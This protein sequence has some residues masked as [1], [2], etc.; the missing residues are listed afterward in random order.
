M[1]SLSG[2]CCDLSC[3]QGG[4]DWEGP[5]GSAVAVGEPDGAGGGEEVCSGEQ[6]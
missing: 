2:G 6:C 4:A 1:N 5:A 3:V